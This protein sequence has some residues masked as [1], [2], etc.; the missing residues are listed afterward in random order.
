VTERTPS[1]TS[2]STRR[3]RAESHIWPSCNSRANAESGQSPRCTAPAINART[4]A[5]SV[6][7]RAASANAPGRQ[8]VH[9]L[10]LANHPL[11][12]PGGPVNSD[13]AQARGPPRCG[14]QD[15]EAAELCCNQAKPVQRR[16]SGEHTAGPAVQQGGHLLLRHRRGT[17]L[18]EIDARQQPLPRA[19]GLGAT[20]Q[21]VSGHTA[22][23][24]LPPRDDVFLCPQDRRQGR[25][26]EFCVTRHV[27]S[28]AFASDRTGGEAQSR[29]RG[30]RESHRCTSGL[31][32]TS[33]EVHRSPP[34][35]PAGSAFGAGLDRAEVG[36]SVGRALGAAYRRV[37]GSLWTAALTCRAV[38][39]GQTSA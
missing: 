39:P 6:R 37:M 38:D 27:R 23:E 4:S 22:A 7:E 26:I 11:R 19:I 31:V 2:S 10:S 28:V 14:H 5:R 13:E 16:L 8:G 33:P 1:A 9:T 17:S 25:A 20:M 24:S 36:R 29:S 35:G 21:D 12:H 18:G 15:I 30:G 34:K 3:S 32:L